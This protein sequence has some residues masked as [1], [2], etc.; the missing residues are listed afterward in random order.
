MGVFRELIKQTALVKSEREHSLCL[1]GKCVRAQS[2]EWAR[3]LYH[4][5]AQRLYML[6]PPNWVLEVRQFYAWL[7]SLINGLMKDVA[8]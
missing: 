8:A 3:E 5:L 6:E 4:R 7:M 1:I 2:T